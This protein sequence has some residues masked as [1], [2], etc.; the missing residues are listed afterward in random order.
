MPAPFDS[1]L[2]GKTGNRFDAHEAL[3]QRVFI[4]VFHWRQSQ[5]AVAHD[6]RGDAVLWL[7][8]AVRVPKHLGVQM[9]VVIDKSRRDRQPICINSTSGRSLEFSHFGD[10][11]VFDSHVGYERGQSGAI[12]NAATT[13]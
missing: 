4:A 8:G 5:P 7:A 13:H 9:G 3:Y 6:D 11:A 1:L 10:L 12:H 2:Q